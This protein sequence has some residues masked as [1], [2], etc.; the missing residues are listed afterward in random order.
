MAATD[1]TDYKTNP[2]AWV[3]KY[4][5]DVFFDLDLS[6]LSDR[7]RASLSKNAEYMKKDYA[8]SARFSIEG[9]ADST[10]SEDYNLR[11]SE[12]RAESVRMYLN[13]QGISKPIVAAAGFGESRPVA[14]NGTAAG[15]QQNRRV[16]LIVSGESIG[17]TN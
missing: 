15:R 14:T 16:E 9:H 10:G 1:A 6:E 5:E 8:S 2:T 4:I 7:A 3:E 11:L 12:R 17:R 13:Q